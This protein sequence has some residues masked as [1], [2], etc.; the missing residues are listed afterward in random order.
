MILAALVILIVTQGPVGPVTVSGQVVDSKGRPASGI[1]LWLS[2]WPGAGAARAVLARAKSGPDG[3]FRID[4]PT[5]KDPRR[6]SLPLAV[7]AYDPDGG[8]AGQ[9]FSRSAPPASGSVTLKLEGPAQATVRVVG[10]DGKPV[11]AS[12]CRRD[13]CTRSPEFSPSPHFSCPTPWLN[14]SRERPTPRAAR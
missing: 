12:P 1:E 8:I 11:P 3:R 14:Y 2:G 9:M 5:E 4:V 7:W 13:G 6:T 10:P